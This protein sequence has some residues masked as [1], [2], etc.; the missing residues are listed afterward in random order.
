MKG[1]FFCVG[2]GPGD[3][4]LIT[5]LAAQTIRACD[6]I[7]VPQSGAK[8]NAVLKIAT[9]FIGE[10]P[11]LYCDMPMTRDKERLAQAHDASA[12][13]I[14]SYL[15]EGENVA[16]LTL[17]D[18]SVYATP[19]YLHRRLKSM[20][21]PTRMISGVPSFCAAA[22]ALDVPLCEGGEALHV[23]PASYP[24]MMRAL[25]SDGTKVLMK[26]GKSISEVVRQI[27]ER[28]LTAMAVECCGMENEKLH[29]SVDTLEDD[30][31]YFCIVLVKDGKN[32]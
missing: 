32:E 26:S 8:E 4:R 13:Q 29:P 22:A 12:R 6:R 31:S 9:E 28:G 1:T 7:A 21:Y 17:G 25:D 20:G 10:K 24:D 14:A 30:A 11:V 16:F 5:F 3:P 23:I 18:P 15:D 2:T 27:Q 19:M